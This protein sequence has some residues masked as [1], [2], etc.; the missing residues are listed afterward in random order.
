MMFLINLRMFHLI[1]A[2]LC[3]V[4]KNQNLIGNFFSPLFLLL[5]FNKLML[6]GQ[7]LLVHLPLPLIDL[8]TK[9]TERKHTNHYAT[10]KVI[11]S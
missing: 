6:A 1:Y 5:T 3:F 11:Q 9:S 4:K 2:Y 8:C 10:G 7:L